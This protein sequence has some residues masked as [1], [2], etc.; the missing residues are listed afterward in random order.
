MSMKRYE[1]CATRLETRGSSPPTKEYV[2]ALVEGIEESGVEACWHSAVD[3]DSRALFPSKVIPNCHKDANFESFHYLIN[4]LHEIGRP[5]IS[6]YSLNHSIGLVEE[7]PDFQMVPMT[8][9]GLPQI[10]PHDNPKRYCCINTPYGKLL[11]E[12]AVEIVRDVGFDGI[13]FDGSTFATGGNKVPGCLCNYCRKRFHDDTGLELPEKPDFSSRTFRIWINWRYNCLMEVWKHVVDSVL[14]VK[15]DAVIC[16]NNYRRR[17]GKPIWTTGIPMRKLGWD[18]IMAGELDLQPL[19]ADFQMKM[20]KAYGCKR[21]VESWMAL[22]DYFNLWVPDIEPLPLE[23]AAVAAASA[24]GVASMGIGVHP[25]QV[26]ETLSAVEKAAAPLMPYVGGE[27][28]EYAAIW[29]SQ[30]TQ[31]FCSGQDFPGGLDNNSF[32]DG[33]HGANELCLHA[34]VQS[35]VVFDDHVRDGELS[36]YP[37]LLAGNAACV[38]KNQARQLQQYVEKGGVLVACHEFGKYD[39]LGY[40]RE[41]PLMNEFLGI[42]SL[43]IARGKPTLE[44]VDGDLIKGCGKWVTF[45]ATQHCLVHQRFFA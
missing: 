9:E 13:W 1:D 43:E 37:V 41:E 15:P 40:S 39:E 23:Q 18:V 45:K 5:V 4:R 8:G 36:Q 24:G 28:V 30:Q 19:Q 16:F 22:C 20:H 6:W 17:R 38:D 33:Y 14:S 21:G 42:K 2:D 32:W 11:P 34:H 25:K 31:D 44:L 12:F 35:S 10:P 3:P 27:T 29:V 26:I 7:H